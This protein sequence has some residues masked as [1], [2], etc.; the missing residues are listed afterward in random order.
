M[1]QLTAEGLTIRTQV[2]IQA[3]IESAV[4]AAFP[5]IDLDE[6]PE[7]QIIGV[8]SEI[9]AEQEETLQALYS[10]FSEDA[11]GLMLDQIM[12][13]TGSLRRAATHSV[14]MATMNV[15]ANKTIRAGAQ[16]AVDGDPDAIFQSTEDAV[17]A[18]GGA[19]NID[20]LFR[21]LDTGPIAA[22]AGSLTE[23]VTPQ[24]GWISVT[25]AEAATLGRAR[26]EDPEARETRRRELA[27]GT[28]A[29]SALRTFVSKVADVIEVRVYENTALT[30]DAI[31]R[32]GKSL[33]VVVWDGAVPAADDDAI[34]QAI[35]DH[36]PEGIE[37]Y[38]VGSSGSA[39]D[40]TGAPVPVAFSRVVVVAGVVVAEVVLAPGTGPAWEDQADAAIVAR[41]A[42]YGIGETAYASQFVCALIKV[43][44]IV[45]VPVLTLDGGASVVVTDR[46]IFRVDVGDV[47]VT[48]AP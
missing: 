17:N 19:L 13:L 16:A 27:S 14:V 25:N 31:G 44:G 30:P 26:A 38:G 45:A 40:D 48:E 23:I 20:I 32:P 28:R 33:E 47:T 12:A 2:E 6:G 29:L 7:H 5:G 36:K 18:T 21:A 15:A 42:E 39:T 43:A 10:G 34:A 37:A 1:A 35:L 24:P 41:G 9:L 8:L 4:R 46:E 22:L 3:L 11:S